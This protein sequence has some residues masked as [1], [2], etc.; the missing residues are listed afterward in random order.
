MAAAIVI[1]VA[2]LLLAMV[3][4]LFR[5]EPSRSVRVAALAGAAS[6]F[7]FALLLGFVFVDGGMN[8]L[9]L[10]LLGAAV[11]P[12]VLLGQFRVVRRLLGAR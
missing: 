1:I 12:L 7:A 2:L 10:A 4:V 9:A 6:G 5:G 11:L 3:T 8:A